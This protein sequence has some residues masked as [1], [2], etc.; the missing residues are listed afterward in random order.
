[1]YNR[2][3]KY[4]NPADRARKTLIWCSLI[5]ITM[6]LLL[7]DLTQT[8]RTAGSALTVDSNI[9]LAFASARSPLMTA[10]FSNVTHLGD[11]VIIII[12]TAAV[13]T[14][15]F[16][17]QRRQ[18]ILGLMLSVGGSAVTTWVVKNLV[19]RPRPGGLIPLY[20]EDSYSFPSGHATATMALYGFLIYVCWKTIPG[21]VPKIGIALLNLAIIL[22]VGFSRL[23]LGVHFPVDV[24]A[25]YLVGGLWVILAIAATEYYLYRTSG[26]VQIS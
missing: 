13:A 9:E 10:L 5:I 2:I 22:G 25:G 3:K 20:I 11:A 12:V 24:L 8:V 17:R 15:L 7:A 21:K 19:A 18:Y 1:M 4:L 26:S 23:Y 14:A 16:F 6:I